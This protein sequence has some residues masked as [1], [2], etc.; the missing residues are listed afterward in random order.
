[1]FRCSN[2]ACLTAAGRDQGTTS[3][4]NSTRFTLRE[5]SGKPFW[6]RNFFLG[7]G[8]G[9]GVGEVCPRFHGQRSRGLL[10]IQWRLF[11]TGLTIEN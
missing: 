10:G 9:G 7:G 6:G 4:K 11:L 3:Q 5:D 2:T 8:G 1:M